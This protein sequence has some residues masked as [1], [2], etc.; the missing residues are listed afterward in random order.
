MRSTCP[1]KV[2]F[3]GKIS[4]PCVSA[5]AVAACIIVSM[6]SGCSRP[7]VRES[8]VD[9]QENHYTAGLQKLDTGDLK[10]AETEFIRA[11]ELD[12]NSPLGFTGMAFVEMDRSNFKEARKYARTAIGKGGGFAD[13]YT[14]LGMAIS[15]LMHGK[16][17]H[18]E[19][20]KYFE[21]ALSIE[22]AN[23][24][25][26][27][28]IAETH[29]RALD[30]PLAL[31]YFTRAAGLNGVFAGRAEDRA[32]FIRKIMKA[33]PLTD[34]GRVIT[35]KDKIS[36]S[37]LCVLLV[38][39]LEVKK[40]L[41]RYRP[42][43][44]RSLFREDF[45]LRSRRVEV[46]SEVTSNRARDWIIDVIH[47]DIPFFGLYPDGRFLPDQLV[48][49]ALMAVVLEW[50]L[51]LVTGDDKLSTRYMGMESPFRDVHT[52]YYAFNAINLCIETG[53]MDNPGD[54]LFNPESTVSGIDALLMLRKVLEGANMK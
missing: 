28:Y 49:K 32:G 6:T 11:V 24:R 29:Y 15:A 22:P 5:L 43:V 37:D 1:E 54:S 51:E 8:N 2:Q 21:K 39:E 34:M 27:F 50:T 12:R 26:N 9:T 30:Y 41:N 14:A 45:G 42:E 44:F 19:A 38:E 7:V 23:E 4:M 46:K 3:M 31:D 33:R 10:S 13:S 16:G 36:R 20:L 40:L 18:G 52:R 48:T 35:E 47:L 25:A 53:I 17:W